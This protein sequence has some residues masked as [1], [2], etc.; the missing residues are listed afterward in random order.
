[1]AKYFDSNDYKENVFTDGKQNHKNN[2]NVVVCDFV[3]NS[4]EEA[5]QL[6]HDV[7]KFE[8]DLFWKRGTYFWAFILGSF[9]A[10]FVTMDKI[11][12]CRELSLCTLLAI[13]I[14]SKLALSI[15]SFICFFF[16]LSWV[17]INKGS[18]FWQK[19][20]EEHIDMLEDSFSG[21]LYKSFLNTKAPEFKKSPFSLK[22]YDYSVTK[23][24]TCG[25]IVLTVI[26]FIMFVFHTALFLGKWLHEF[27]YENLCFFTLIFLVIIF[28]VIFSV[29]K[30]LS[31]TGNTDNDSE[32]QK[33]WFQR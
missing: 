33:K 17:L 5:F 31:C 7:R 4:E 15:I 16:C 8:I 13:P 18:K 23:V 6:A 27:F 32:Q 19:N 11:L 22:A 28:V 30:L 25:S 14:L 12:G 3:H 20:W 1:M 21:K 10:Y 29:V 24:T 26:S 9:T 2:D